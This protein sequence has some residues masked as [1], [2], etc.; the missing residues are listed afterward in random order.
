M[1]VLTGRGLPV[2]ECELVRA[3]ITTHDPATPCDVEIVIIGDQPGAGI[4]TNGVVFAA[5]RG[6]AACVPK[7]IVFKDSRSAGEAP[8]SERIVA[9]VNDRSAADEDAVEI[10][11]A[12]TV[13]LILNPL[14][15]LARRDRV[16]CGIDAQL[17][18]VVGN[19]HVGS[20]G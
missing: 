17:N 8:E 9:R 20:S 1:C 13:I 15:V 14:H 19:N 5:A 12:G 2:R 10:V 4:G 7:D 16:P 3:A 11:L 6:D 18:H